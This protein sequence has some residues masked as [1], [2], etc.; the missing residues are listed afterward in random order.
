M[1]ATATPIQPIDDKAAKVLAEKARSRAYHRAVMALRKA[2]HDE[3]EDLYAK[4][5]ANEGVSYT[6]RLTPEEKAAKQIEALLTKFPNLRN[7]ADA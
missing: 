5:C 7:P 4:A 2:H 3:W 6:R 1:T